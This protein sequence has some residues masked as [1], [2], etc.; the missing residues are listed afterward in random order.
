ML[1][2]LEKH[3]GTVALP[4]MG[5][6]DFMGYRSSMGHKKGCGVRVQILQW[7]LHGLPEVTDGGDTQVEWH[8]PG[9]DGFTGMRQQAW[10]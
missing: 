2:V 6:W 9:R 5:A 10:V 1:V 4:D 3:C 8:Q 7:V